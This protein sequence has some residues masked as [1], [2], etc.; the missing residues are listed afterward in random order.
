[1]EKFDAII[2][3]TGQAGPALAASL[4]KNGFKTAIIEK[5]HLGGTCVNVGCTPT[6]A[7]VASARRVFAA[8]NSEEHG[9]ILEGNLKIDLKR[10]K[11]RKDKLIQDSRS[12]LEK[13]FADTE[14]LTLIRGKATFLDQHTVQVKNEKYTAAKFY[15]NVGGRP[16][17]P[18]DFKAIDYLTNESIL[19]LEDIP[20]HLVIIGGGYIGLEFGQ[21]FRRFGSKVTILEKGDQ[22]LKKEDDDIAQEIAEILKDSGIDVKLNSD[23]ISAEKSDTGISVNYNCEGNIE[24]IKASHVLVATGRIPNTDDLGLDKAGVK[25]DKAGFIVVNNELQTS[26]AHIWALGDCN[27]EGAFTHTAYN[28]FQIVNSHLFEER[29]RYL[30]D[31]FTCYAAFIDPPLARVGLNETDIKKQGL[32]AKV[33][34]RPMSKIARA[35]EKGE[36][37]GKLKIFIEN[38]TNKILGATFLGAG[39]DEY[40][41]TVIDQMYAGASYEVIRDAIHIHPTVSEL[42]PTMLENPKEL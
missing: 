4:A 42:L 18:E 20:E 27:G 38:E 28:D 19:E 9:V 30:S 21:M 34:I 12:G 14:N 31:R 41:H 15:I 37:A 10:I 1:M 8:G 40:I 24:K 6:K 35:K 5:G 29:K 2:I 13:M 22:L 16:R 7:Y 3:G 39:A 25:L 26:A 32:K 11:Q 23:C 33:A 17:I 36:T